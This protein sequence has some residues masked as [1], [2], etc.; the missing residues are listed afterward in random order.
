MPRLPFPTN[1]T[2]ILKAALLTLFVATVVVSCATLPP[3]NEVVSTGMTN[4]V[5]TS[6]T[7]F[8]GSQRVLVRSDGGTLY[9][10]YTKKIAGVD[11]VY[12]ARS[13]DNGKSWSDYPQISFGD[14]N[15]NNPDIVI[16]KRGHLRVF[17]T[18]HEL[19][20][21][22][23][24]PS[25]GWGTSRSAGASGADKT[26]NSASAWNKSSGGTAAQQAAVA[27]NGFV[28]PGQ[29]T[30][31]GYDGDYG[32]IRQLF[33]SSFNGSRWSPQV[34]LTHGDYNGFPSAAYDSRGV[35]H[36]V[37]YG[38][39]GRNYQVIYSALKG[40][41]WTP[42]HQISVGY[43]DS[44]NPSV[45]VDS[46]NNLHV[47]WYKYS[48]ASK[49]Y[50]IYYREYRQQTRSWSPG[51]EE[52][53][54]GLLQAENVSLAVAANGTVWVAWEGLVSRHAVTGV[55]VRSLKNGTWSSQKMV[56]LPGQAA[57]EPS[58]T[59]DARGNVFVFYQGDKDHQIYVARY[60]GHAWR[61]ARKITDAGKNGYPNARLAIGPLAT[62]GGD[63][64]DL[65]WT[66][67]GEAPSSLIGKNRI[68]FATL[69]QK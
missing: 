13:T 16:D 44:V 66:Q 7:T 47:V 5:P 4:G 10:A 49:S 11:Q 60:D 19:T 22:T 35:L 36:M 24:E 64:I 14:T 69:M 1:P 48:P 46:E 28:K 57:T 20:P 56:S 25:T 62:A 23:G 6:G 8:A 27:K 55:Y 32:T 54:E 34:Q 2:S 65:V 37:W 50:Q 30:G 63:R 17:W 39:D 12:V 9:L 67:L 53:S 45:A 58:V 38:Y 29:Q 59:A 15:S 68:H 43:P 3:A 21:P 61:L 41:H 52:I 42:P 33:M 18:K 31:E 26:A 40:G 51:D